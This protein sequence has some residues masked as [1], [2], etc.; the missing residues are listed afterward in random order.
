MR[1]AGVEIL[2][3]S[4][5][6]SVVGVWEALVRLGKLR[7]ALERIKSEIASRRPDLVVL[8]DYPGM[9]LRLAKFARSIGVK[10]MYY[11]SPQVWAWGGGR[12]NVIRRNVDRLVVILPFEVE[13]YRRKGVDAKYVGHP[14]IDIVRTNLDR[15]TFFKRTGLGEGGKIVS[16]LPGSRLQE[17]KQ[18]LR[19]LLETASVLR[20]SVPDA[21]FVLVTLPAHEEMVR[22][23]IE[24]TGAEVKVATESRYEA[25]AYSDL[26]ITCSGTVTLEVALL[27]TPMIV[28]YRLAAFSWALGRLIVKVPYISLVNLVAREMI[29][30]E[31]IQAEVKPEMLAA[32]AARMLADEPRR[33]FIRERLAQVRSRLGPGGATKRAAEAALELIPE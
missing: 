18:H 21:K 16:L 9:N 7:A 24:R 23:E 2:L 12:I 26:A 31:F 20:R 19:P 13:L 32:E 27:G 15:S 17:I 33:R 3:D 28:I 14:L 11:I 6:I 30:P 22:R 25:M 8:I 4:G 5:E 10:V 29:V 1:A